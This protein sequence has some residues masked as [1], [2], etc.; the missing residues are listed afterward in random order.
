MRI[1]ELLQ[2]RAAFTRIRAH[3]LGVEDDVAG[4]D[5]ELD[6]RI[7]VARLAIL[8]CRDRL[9]QLLAAELEREPV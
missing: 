4:V 8:D 1:D 6:Q 7:A 5:D 9:E 2:V 3:W